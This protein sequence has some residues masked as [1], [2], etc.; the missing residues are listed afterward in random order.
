MGN[1]RGIATKIPGNLLGA[2]YKGLVPHWS[3]ARHVKNALD[4]LNLGNKGQS[5]NGRQM[6]AEIAGDEHRL[7]QVAALNL[8]LPAV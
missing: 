6:R 8:L 3:T 2:K 5:V 4:I 7:L 1:P